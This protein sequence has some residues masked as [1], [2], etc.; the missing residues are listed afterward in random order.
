MKAKIC[1]WVFSAVFVL[2][3]A[4]SFATFPFP[5]PDTGQTTCYDDEFVGNVLNPCPSPGEALYGQ[6]A[7]Y[8][9]NP[10]SYTKLDASGN[11]LPVNAADWAMIR[12]NVTGLIWEHKTD[13]G[14]IH[15]KDNAY[16]WYDSNP[17]TNGGHPGTPGNGT[18]TEDFINALN[19]Q[20]FGGFSDWRLPSIKELSQIVNYDETA[21]ALN[22]TYFSNTAWKSDPL[23][24]LLYWSSSTHVHDATKVNMLN[25]HNGYEYVFMKSETFP[26][27]AVRGTA[28]SPASRKNGDGTVSDLSTGLMW[29]ED[30]GDT[31][32]DGDLD[33]DDEVTW[34]EALAWCENLTFAGYDDWRMPNF[35]ELRSIVEYDIGM[36]AI[37]TNY[38]S[39]V[40]GGQAACWS[41]TSYVTV[42][43]TGRPLYEDA[44]LVL[45]ED[46]NIMYFWKGF[47]F[48][49]RPVRN[50]QEPN[51]PPTADAGDDRIVMEGTVETLDGS[52]SFDTDDGINTYFWEQTA[53][54]AATLSDPTAVKPTFIVPAITPGIGLY[55]GTASGTAWDTTPI[56]CEWELDI[57]ADGNMTFAGTGITYIGDVSGSGTVDETG[58]VSMVIDIPSIGPV[59]GT[60]Q[61]DLDGNFTF[62]MPDVNFSFVAAF[63]SDGR[64]SGT[65]EV[66]ST[67]AGDFT[68]AF[69]M[70]FQLTVTDHYCGVSADTVSLII[71]NAPEICDGIDNDHD[72]L[73][74]EGCQTWYQDN[75][76][77]MYGDPGVSI[78]AIFQPA[79]FVT[80]NT[81]CDDTD[82]TVNPGAAEVCDGKDNDCDGD[83]DEGCSTWYADSDGDTYGDPAVFVI[84]TVQPA[85][86]VAD[87]TDC[88]DTDAG[89]HPGAAEICG[90]GIDEDCSGADLPCCGNNLPPVADAGE[91][92]LVLENTMVTLNGSDSYDPDGT[93]VTY[94]WTQTGGP[95]VTLSDAAAVQPTFTV[96]DNSAGQSLT[97]KLDVT[98]DCG[99]SD[100]GRVQLIVD[101]EAC[102]SQPDPPVLVSPEDG[103][104]DV[105]RKPRLQTEPYSEPEQCST[106]FKTRWQISDHDDFHGLTYNAN[107]FFPNLT[108]HRVTKKVLKPDTT[109]YWRVKFWGDHGIK[110]EWSEVHSFTTAPCNSGCNQGQV[111]DGQE[112]DVNGNGIPDAREPNLR[113]LVT[114]DG[115]T[116]IG[117][118]FSDNVTSIDIETLDADEV[119]DPDNMPAN[120][121]YGLISF[122]IEVENPGDTASFTVFLAEP[123]PVDGVWY[124]YDTV[125]GW[126]DFTDRITFGADRKSLTFELTDGGIGD[127][128][129]V[130]NA[131]IVD[132][133]G[134]AAGIVPSGSSGHSSGSTCFIDTF[135]KN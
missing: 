114:P 14:G 134:L 101:E 7:Q 20:N 99:A 92:R 13:D 72:G 133:A 19:T 62:T 110:S 75:D 125:N 95:G 50:F 4:T 16:T 127:A 116:L 96:P 97:F 66:P 83:V 2:G 38:Y 12:D 3:T 63:T 86:Y 129:G 79:G 106:H 44:W 47:E 71:T 53:G 80:D 39:N 122:R 61:I 130:A 54:P 28:A 24:Y 113:A 87:N 70:I 131:V 43:D 41:S 69:T 60:G 23:V 56:Q 52:G 126:Y 128:D 48:F 68:G 121:I 59:P 84:D 78:F 111:P 35:N 124:K 64:L 88:D 104:V 29:T 33:E 46:G 119:G 9:F 8:S 15:D 34:R 31:D 65:W 26:V 102:N 22:T 5:V 118:E 112:T 57:D 25:F 85:G 55:Q 76:G 90:N 67:A 94:A 37:D 73:I 32:G 120:L 123:A 58:F 117:V 89:I 91:D 36:P 27:R 11:D 132:P 1:L 107:T 40:L 103:A 17:A 49:V 108:S 10:P 135:R 6:D 51:I 109:Y 77:D 82:A 18:D 93:I 115:T 74:D 81:D 98:D 42:H 45:P 21:P 30:I 105:S 100:M